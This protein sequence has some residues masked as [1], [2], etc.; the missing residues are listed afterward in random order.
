MHDMIVDEE[1]IKDEF[2]EVEEED[3]HNPRNAFTIYDGPFDHAGNRIRHDSDERANQFA[4]FGERLTFLNSAFINIK[5]QNDL[6]KHNWNMEIG[7]Q[8]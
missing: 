8:L 1:F 7:E 6:V 3:P 5:L 2:V 4:V